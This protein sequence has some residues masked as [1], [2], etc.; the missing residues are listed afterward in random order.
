MAYTRVRKVLTVLLVWMA[1]TTTA[2]N[3]RDASGR[4]QGHWTEKRKWGA[5]IRTESGLYKNNLREGEWQLEYRPV[6]EQ[7]G[8]HTLNGKY[9][10]G[11]RDGTWTR[12]GI[13]SDWNATLEYLRDTLLRDGD[14]YW[15]SA[16]HDT[17]YSIE[18]F[19]GGPGAKRIFRRWVRTDWT[20]RTIDSL[21]YFQQ[22]NYTF[23][24]W[25]DYSI[26]RLKEEHLEDRWHNRYADTYIDLKTGIRQTNEI[27]GP[28]DMD[29][30]GRFPIWPTRFAWYENG[31][32][33]I[34]QQLDS[35]HAQMTIH[36]TRDSTGQLLSRD[37]R[38]RYKGDSAI[39]RDTF[40][41]H[42]RVTG[43]RKQL[44][45]FSRASARFGTFCEYH[46]YP[47]GTMSSFIESD[48][49]VHRMTI[50]YYPSGKIKYAWMMGEDGEWT[51]RY[52][53]DGSLL[54]KFY[55]EFHNPE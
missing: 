23:C 37:T 50:D 54:S 43:Y 19:S 4:K 3:Q 39:S 34:F 41:D 33:H 29:T 30:E 44:V 46:F 1:F 55:I 48:E 36:E 22:P 28:L 7:Y 21:G 17:A 2:Q 32:P 5:G 11:L 40:Y 18:W 25:Y 24:Q 45:T 8:Q 52:D 51:C 10:D 27:S 35:T 47:D 26:D 31:T 14:S 53:E 12:K 42:G 20:T 9:V 15:L 13:T 49:N 38:I 16:N 6:K